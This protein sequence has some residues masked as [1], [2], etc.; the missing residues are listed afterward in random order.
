ME[1]VLRAYDILVIGRPSVDLIF[2]GLPAWPAVGREVFARDLVVSAGGTFNVVAALHRLGLRVG[3]IGSVGN[4]PWSEQALH[5][6]R[7]EGVATDL[8]QRLNH[9][10]PNLSICM[11]HDGDRGFLTYDPADETVSGTCTA[12]A[13]SLLKRERAAFVQCCLNPDLAAYAKIAHERGMRVIVDFC[14][15]EP[16]L[17]SRQIWTLA[18][19]ADI[20]FANEPEAQTV[21]GEDEPVKAL[22]RLAELAPIVVVKRGADGASAMVDGREYHAPTT[23]VE[24]VDAT[25]AGDC[26]NAG[27]LYGL[28]H[29]RPIGECL[30]Y[31]NICGGLSVAV[32]GG[33]AGAPTEAE[34][35]ARARALDIA[36]VEG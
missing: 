4:D 12:H 36:S 29:E 13:L 30:R 9:P 14:W 3:L 22:R 6:M 19:L 16:W 27:F 33:F 17:S 24:V 25:G 5:G 15:D 18:A 2:T 1:R 20:I 23:A 34:L 28:L 26:F 21:T 10:L 32:S 8:I 31:G 11:A 35:L 7:H